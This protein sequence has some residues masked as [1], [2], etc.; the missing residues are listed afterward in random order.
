MRLQAGLSSA[1]KAVSSSGLDAATKT[2]VG[3]TEAAVTT[4]K[5]AVEQV[6]QPVTGWQH[7][8]CFKRVLWDTLE[9]PRA[10]GPTTHAAVSTAK[11]AVDQ[12]CGS[13]REQ[14]ESS[15][16]SFSMY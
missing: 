5:P 2:V 7:L 13:C 8:A 9:K 15:E 10:A 14:N 4:A 1:Q 16:Y 3:T 6:C 11:P 12:V